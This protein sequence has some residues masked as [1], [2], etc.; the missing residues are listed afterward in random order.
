MLIKTQLSLKN[1]LQSRFVSYKHRVSSISFCQ[2][3]A[4]FGILM[5]DFGGKG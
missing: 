4:L 2:E 3:S 5:V 1:T